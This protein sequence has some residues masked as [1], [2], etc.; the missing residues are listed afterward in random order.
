MWVGMGRKTVT[1]NTDTLASEE[2][3]AMNVGPWMMCFG[4]FLL[5]PGLWFFLGYWLGSN[6]ISI[7]F[8]RESDEDSVGYSSN[9]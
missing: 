3:E 7:S 4:V 9:K 8:N 6:K 1:R 2:A 5:W